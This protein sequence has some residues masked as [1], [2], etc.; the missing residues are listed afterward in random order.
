M[1]YAFSVYILHLETFAVFSIQNQYKIYRVTV[2]VIHE[3]NIAMKKACNVQQINE[4]I[5][6]P[7]ASPMT[8]CK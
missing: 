2:F 6:P 7:S 4:N 3:R 8:T 5:G 1:S